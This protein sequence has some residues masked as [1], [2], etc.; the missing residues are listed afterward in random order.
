MVY[1][2]INPSTWVYEKEGDF[3]EGV[4]VRSESD[5]GV[6]KSNIYTLEVS[7]GKFIGVWGS[8]ILDQRMNLVNVGD[9][10]KITYKGLSEKKAGKNPAKIFKVEVDQEDNTQ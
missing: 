7:P 6:N 9:K 10:V 2:E 8:T 5:V 3:I 1:K 4:L